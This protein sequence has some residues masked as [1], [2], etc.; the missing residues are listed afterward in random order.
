MFY[1]L[2]VDLGGGEKTFAVAIRE[3]T[4]VGL[5]IEKSLSLKNNSPK[6]SSMVEIIEFV[7]KNP[8]LGTAIDAPLSFSINLEKGFRASDLALRSL[9]PREYRKWVLSYHALMGIPLRGLLLAQK[10]SP[11]CGAIL[12]THPRASFFFLL[13][14][15]KRYLAHKYK[16][17]PLEEEEINY[18]KNYFKKLF[19]IELTHTF[20][21]DDL[22]DALICAL[23]SY[24]FF[25]KP[26]KLLFLPQE[27]KDLFGFGPF[28]IIGE[29]FL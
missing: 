7:R 12:E 22:L 24:L 16:R 21:Y 5:H 26:E 6:P 17:E 13:P 28:V 15:E 18:L 14:K 3:K 20:F 1:Y 29:S 8:V 19:S 9:L 2:G 11:Y 10:L 27:E 25:K 4:N 23:T